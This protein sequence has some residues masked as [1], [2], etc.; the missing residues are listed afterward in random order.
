MSKRRARLPSEKK[1]GT[2]AI[3]GEKDPLGVDLH[4]QLSDLS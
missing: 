4:L 3:Y 2:P 1:I